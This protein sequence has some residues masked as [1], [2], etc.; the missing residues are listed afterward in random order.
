MA[1]T[2]I[3][4]PIRTVSES[5]ARRCSPVVRNREGLLSLLLDIDRQGWDSA[6][7]EE[8][9]EYVRATVVRPNVASSSLRGLA[10]EQ[11]EATAWE[12]TWEVLAAPSL[13]VARSPWGVL[14]ATARRAVLGE[15]VAGT[16]CTDVRTAWRLARQPVVDENAR[17]PGAGTTAVTHRPPVSLVELSRRGV[18]LPADPDDWVGLAAGPVLSLVVRAL[19]E[20]GWVELDAR[21]VVDAVAA[22][23]DRNGSTSGAARGWR[24]LAEWLD[25]PPWQVRRATVVM[26]GAPDWPGLVERLMTEGRAVLEDPGV[27]AAIRSTVIPSSLTP[28]TAAKRVMDPG[29]GGRDRA[30]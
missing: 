27:Q 9:L 22:T 18:D 16:Y 4:R 3:D 14:W 21:R 15:L 13:R 8:L 11:A 26:L 6:T 24:H 1:A 7:A 25:L 10:A 2:V 23:A 19:V 20:A 12:A 29:Q 5:G 30:A 17:R 28:A